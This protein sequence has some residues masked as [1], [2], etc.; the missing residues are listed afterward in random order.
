MVSPF[1]QIDIQLLFFLSPSGI[2]NEYKLFH[3]GL[4]VYNSP[5]V[6]QHLI[7]G[8]SPWSLHVLRVE[9]CTSRGCGSSAEVRARTMEAPP[10]GQIGL[11]LRVS[12]QRSVDVKW[13]AVEVE[14]GEV[15][16]DVYVEG[17]EY[18]DPG[19]I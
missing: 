17:L 18:V 2:I 10:E 16:Y 7:G 1:L 4:L 11:G 3:N 9:A 6:R 14:N 5:T 12:G 19:E 15:A 13:N 8:L